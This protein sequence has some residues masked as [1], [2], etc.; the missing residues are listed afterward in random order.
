MY[1]YPHW[2]ESSRCDA[3]KLGY[4]LTNIA[5]E[6]N[7]SIPELSEQIGLKRPTLTAAIR[8]GHVTRLCGNALIEK[9]K[10]TAIKAE[11]LNFIK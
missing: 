5:G 6:N 9:T 2:I 3:K 10:D 4:L 7:I 8:R 1:K 11:L